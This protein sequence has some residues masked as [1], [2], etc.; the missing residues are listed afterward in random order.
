[1]ADLFT[2][3][4]LVGVVAVCHVFVLFFKRFLAAT[5]ILFRIILLA[6]LIY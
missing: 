2:T 4:M 6:K 1:M 3:D 5:N